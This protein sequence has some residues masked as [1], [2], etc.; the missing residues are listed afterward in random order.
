[1]AYRQDPDSLYHHGYD[2]VGNEYY[3]DRDG[4]IYN[5]N[6]YMIE[7]SNRVKAERYEAQRQEEQRRQQEYER[8]QQAAYEERSSYASGGYSGGSDM[9]FLGGLGD[10]GGIAI[11]G[12]GVV[13][14]LFTGV[15]VLILAYVSKLLSP[16][17]W[18]IG[19]IWEI[20]KILFTAWPTAI[21]RCLA[22]G[23]FGNYFHSFGTN[24]IYPVEILLAIGLIIYT[25][26]KYVSS[27]A[28]WLDDTPYGAA[29]I[30][31]PAMEILYHF[32]ATGAWKLGLFVAALKGIFL[33]IPVLIIL[34][35]ITVI[36]DKA[37]G[38]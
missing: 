21:H 31:Y 34:Y 4:N 9:S 6:G 36:G 12:L 29:L 17:F 16:V 10:L 20:I 5:S 22:I 24:W 7:E 27:Y 2:H 25:V 38:F 3:E 15:F 26:R 35:V 37:N 19:K 11:A 14:F 30:A 1:M 28:S 23:G 13:P 33:A 32:T 18:L 8:R